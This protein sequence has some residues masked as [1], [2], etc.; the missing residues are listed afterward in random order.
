M[1]YQ[2]WDAPD[3]PL[4]ACHLF[5]RLSAASSLI[6]GMLT[7]FAPTP[8]L[9]FAFCSLTCCCARQLTTVDGAGKQLHRS[10]WECSPRERVGHI[11]SQYI[12]CSHTSA[13]GAR[14]RANAPVESTPW[15]GMHY[16][17]PAMSLQH[18]SG[19][20]DTEIAAQCLL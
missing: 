19:H 18:Q 3:Q 7:P 2:V 11:R 14:P 12:P 10:T 13:S 8:H 6:S 5:T 4:S 9:Q 17:M 20:L 1:P 16:S 15:P